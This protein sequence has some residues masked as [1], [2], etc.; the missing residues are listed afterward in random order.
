[1]P[2]KGGFF[3]LP[4]LGLAIA[5]VPDHRQCHDNLHPVRGSIS[6]LGSSEYR[7]ISSPNC[8]FS[9]PDVAHLRDQNCNAM[10][11]IRNELQGLMRVEAVRR[12]HITCRHDCGL[13]R[14]TN[15]RSHTCQNKMMP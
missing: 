4:V 6:D 14:S 10:D 5:S 13:E 15:A 7:R 12:G 2:V 1:M 8:E 9:F 11:R 3:D